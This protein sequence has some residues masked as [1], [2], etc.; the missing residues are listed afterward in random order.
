M[1]LNIKNALSKKRRTGKT[2]NLVVSAIASWLQ[3]EQIVFRA[4]N[5]QTLD[6]IKCRLIVLMPGM[7]DDIQKVKFLIG[8]KSGREL[9][10][11]PSH[12]LLFDDEPELFRD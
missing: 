1:R 9:H 7:K 4:H 3:G 10:G 11:L 5:A 8:T 12:A 6:I 2:T